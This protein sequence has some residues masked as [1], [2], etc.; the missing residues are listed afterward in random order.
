MSIDFYKN[1]LIDNNYYFRLSVLLY[2][3][4]IENNF[5]LAIDMSTL[6]LIHIDNDNQGS[7]ALPLLA[8]K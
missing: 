3:R 5:Q 4:I 6:L 1:F 2:Q 8:S 7:K